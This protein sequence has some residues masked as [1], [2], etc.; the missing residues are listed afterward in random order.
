L[1]PSYNPFD[2]DPGDFDDLPPSG[3]TPP[4]KLTHTSPFNGHF[5]G[6]ANYEHPRFPGKT[7]R[8]FA[9]QDQNNLQFGNIN[10][11]TMGRRNTASATNNGV[12]TRRTSARRN[13]NAGDDDD[14]TVLEENQCQV[15]QDSSGEEEE[16]PPVV[17][18]K[19][20]QELIFN[21]KPWPIPTTS[22]LR[23]ENIITAVTKLE[24]FRFAYVKLKGA[25][26]EMEANYAQMRHD[27]HEAQTELA[28]FTKND[29]TL[30]TVK[31]VVEAKLFP[32]F[33]FITCK[34]KQKELATYVYKWIQEEEL[35]RRLTT[36]DK[37]D[38]NYLAK[39]IKTYG[40]EVTSFLNG[41]RG[42]CTQ[43]ML[44]EW[45]KLFKGD[46][47]RFYGPNKFPTIAE[48]KK[49]AL[50]DIDMENEREVIIFE[51]YITV[52]FCKSV[53]KY[54]QEPH[55][56]CNVPV[57]SPPPAVY[58]PARSIG[59]SQWKR[60]LWFK[61]LPLQA[62]NTN[63]HVAK[64]KQHQ[65]P[66]FQPSMEAFII[67]N[68]DN[69][70]TRWEARAAHYEKAKNWSATLP[71]RKHRVDE[72]GK[73]VYLPDPI[74]D[75]KYSSSSK[76]NIPFGSWNKAGLTFFSECMKEIQDARANKAIMTKMEAFEVTFRT[77]LQDKYKIGGAYGQKKSKKR[78]VGEDQPEAEAPTIAMD[79]EQIADGMFV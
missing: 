68:Y 1:D 31:K 56:F 74:Y 49:C 72:N 78:K 69:N 40:P 41:S 29:A 11:T 35:G 7:P 25:Y 26:E 8:H 38:P 4:L 6:G 20:K 9:Q 17:V 34:E 52:L 63:F 65:V 48:L 64:G 16:D 45:K 19:E 60:A 42:D 27:L 33:K 50:R 44:S 5:V 55:Y 54:D 79:V 70:K 59:N 39:W 28:K 43:R 61:E 51:W 46:L 30:A 22:T 2:S 66:L 57:V 12:E 10:S 24:K 75:G 3:S 14:E 15:E 62:E 32:L 36:E 23:K 21:G 13:N 37:I 53:I 18:G 58:F 67:A 47:K 76:G 77:F 73:T 71:P